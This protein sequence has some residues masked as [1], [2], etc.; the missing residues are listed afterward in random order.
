L[1]AASPTRLA[2]CGAGHAE[3][4]VQRVVCPRNSASVKYAAECSGR[5]EGIEALLRADWSG[6]GPGGFHD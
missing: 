5:K 4:A 6:K 1:R 3:S 2:T